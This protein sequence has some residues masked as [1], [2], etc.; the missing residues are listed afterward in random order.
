MKLIRITILAAVL[1]TGMAFAGCS[2]DDS[3]PVAV[4]EKP[5]PGFMAPGFELENFDGESI[6]L[7]SLR[8]RPVMLNF[9]A[10]WC[11]PCRFEMPFIQEI[12]EDPAW[13]EKDLLIIAVNIGEPASQARAFMNDFGFTFT[14]LLDEET[15]VA[16]QYN[17]SGIPTT[18]FIDKDGII[19]DIRVGTFRGKAEIEQYL[20]K[21][22]AE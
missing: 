11:G 20:Q 18:C 9:W 6:A 19:K 17:I 5:A 12:H 22:V 8:G 7:G 10:T 14:V 15:E 1:L 13:L 21:L 3:A 4:D 2:S 16:K